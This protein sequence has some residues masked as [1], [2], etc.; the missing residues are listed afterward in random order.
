V[1]LFAVI[2]T[3]AAW[4]TWQDCRGRQPDNMC[5]QFTSFRVGFA[6]VTI[7]VAAVIGWLAIVRGSILA[8]LVGMAAL[9]AWTLLL[10]LKT[11][12]FC[13]QGIDRCEGDGLAAMQRIDL[14][15]GYTI[16][17]AATGSL[18]GIFVRLRR[19]RRAQATA[20]RGPA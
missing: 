2:P 7:S 18:V 14:I 4:E 16:L 15:L 1:A 19:W 11:S 13:P 17:V 5:H 10:F 3:E 8:T 6:A 9:A 12:D 20:G